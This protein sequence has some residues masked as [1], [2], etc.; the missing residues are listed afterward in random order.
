MCL[1]CSAKSRPELS[2]TPTRWAGFGRSAKIIVGA[3]VID[4]IL[5]IV[6]LAVIAAIASGGSLK[7]LHPGVLL[8]EGAAFALFTIFLAPRIVRRIHPQVEPLSTH[9]A[10]L[11]VALAICL[12]LS[13]LSA[14]IGMAAIIGAFFAR[15]MFADYAPQWNLIPRVGGI[16][17][18]LAHF[19]FF[20]MGSRLD[21][22]LFNGSVL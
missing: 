2:S 3:A 22:H 7:W 13:W 19:F 18:F 10:W 15:L 6:L 20:S 14:K 4:D 12:F 17:E 16:T 11:I 8:V 21:V 9:N 1:V 5:G